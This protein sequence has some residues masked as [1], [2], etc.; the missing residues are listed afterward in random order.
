MRA[1]I[2]AAWAVT[3]GCTSIAAGQDLK[4]VAPADWT[5]VASEAAATLVPRPTSLAG[6]AT[7]T[8][9]SP[10]HR[11]RI[12]AMSVSPDGTRVAT[13]GS[14][15]I[16]RIWN[17][18][19]GALDRALMA[20]RHGI[21]LVAWSPDGGLL[22]THAACDQTTRVWEV[23]SGRERTRVTGWNGISRIAWSPDSRVLAAATPGSGKVFVSQAFAAPKEIKQM[24]TSVIAMQWSPA[25]DRLAVA[26]A[27]SPVSLLNPADGQGLRSLEVSGNEQSLTLAWSPDG[28]AIAVGT[29]SEVTV[30]GASGDQPRMKL[31]TPALQVAWSPDSTNLLVNASGNVQIFP[32]EAAET[33]RPRHR[34]AA[35]TWSL[36]EWARRS[37]R[38]VGV[39]ADRIDV[40]ESDG[41]KVQS[42]DAGGAAAPV[43]AA[44]K[45]I[46]T[47][48]GTPGLTVWDA[49]TFSR[50]TA[51]EGH[52]QPVSTAAWSPDGRWLASGDEAGT[53]RVWPVGR[54]G[55]PAAWQG[56]ERRIAVLAW[57]PDGKRLAS[58]ASGDTVTRLWTE[59]GAAAG[60]LEG[61]AKSVLSLAWAPNGRMLATGGAD[62]QVFIWEADPVARQRAVEFTEPVRALAWSAG[63]G[64]PVVACGLGDAVVRFFNPT[65]GA[66]LGGF[67]DQRG[68]GL[69]TDAALAWMPGAVLVARNQLVQAWDTAAVKPV[70]RQMAVNRAADVA[71]AA[72]GAV[73]TVRANDRTV[74]FHGANNSQWSG[75]LLDAAGVPVAIGPTGDVKYPA[76]ATPELIAIAVTPDGHQA[77]LPLDEFAERHGW[78]AT[79]KSIK[80]PAK[81]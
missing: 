47:G 33:A 80:L 19:T 57:S 77:M 29:P 12:S 3:L 39:S 37:G 63:K 31:A 15:G 34:F 53:I 50:I 67:E 81:P 27:G 41:K 43:F 28:T 24:G 36:V 14:D 60:A 58:V 44:G 30:W 9:E 71:V 5:W 49:K 7:W 11:G 73:V 8:L 68:E 35:P 23:E 48:M 62:E 64:G 18:E 52:A 69:V 76:D 25:G 42:I 75:A 1:T 54:E 72:G 2:L 16:V 26:A 51:L 22:A 38:I 45:P 56:H 17:L 74:R 59:T 13:G 40:V 70:M 66:A 61:H 46:V 4:K 32:A 79:A 78:K 10:R 65:T 21:Y 20:H 55:E 6:V